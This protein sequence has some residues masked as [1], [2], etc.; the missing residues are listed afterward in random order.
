MR[1]DVAR[2]GMSVW[3]EAMDLAPTQPDIALQ[4]ISHL[5]IMVTILVTL[6]FQISRL[7]FKSVAK[8]AITGLDVERKASLC[9]QLRTSQR[10]R[11]SL[12]VRK[13]K[14][15]SRV[16]ICCTGGGREGDGENG[17]GGY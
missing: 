14:A 15:L 10:M 12:S 11:P 8:D 1:L 6:W 5:P 2:A 7:C 17:R 3:Y 4:A 13:A 9:H 16:N